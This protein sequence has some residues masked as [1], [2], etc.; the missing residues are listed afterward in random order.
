MEFD[1]YSD[2]ESSDEEVAVNAENDRAEKL[3]NHNRLI[4]DVTRQCQTLYRITGRRPKECKKQVR[5]RVTRTNPPGFATK[6]AQLFET[7]LSTVNEVHSLQLFPLTLRGVLGEMEEG[8][9]ILAECKS[10]SETQVLA[11][12]AID[13]AK[14]AGRAC[15]GTTLG[16]MANSCAT[17]D[18]KNK[19]LTTRR[20]A[21]LTNASISTVNRNKQQVSKGNFGTFVT[22]QKKAIHAKCLS[23]DGDGGYQSVDGGAESVSVGGHQDYLL[24][25][26]I[27]R[28]FLLRRLPVCRWADRHIRVG[29]GRMR[30]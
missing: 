11:Q 26:E 6:V 3:D 30:W 12:A 9:V 14:K 28:K 27:Q 17:E 20:I 4:E 25:D 24:D 7:L 22:L 13:I 16:I 29:I 15:F 1:A 21:E 23:R 8:K 10:K 18:V 5:I 19:K 2:A